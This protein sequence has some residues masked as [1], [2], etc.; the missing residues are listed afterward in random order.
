MIHRRCWG[1]EVKT[2]SFTCHSAPSGLQ[3]VMGQ[4]IIKF[5]VTQDPWRGWDVQS[6][7]MCRAGTLGFVVSPEMSPAWGGGERKIFLISP[8]TASHTSGKRGGEPWAVDL[9]SGP[10]S[11]MPARAD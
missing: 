6:R 11:A 10:M 3:S 2:L 8:A 4:E 9:V 1:H 7:L 5:H